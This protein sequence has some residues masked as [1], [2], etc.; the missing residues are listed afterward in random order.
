VVAVASV[1]E[2]L[3]PWAVVG[4]GVVSGAGVLVLIHA[5]RTWLSLV[6]AVRAAH[7][8]D[9]P[10]PSPVPWVD[11]RLWRAANG[12]DPDL[13]A[14]MILRAEVEPGLVVYPHDV[15]PAIREPLLRPVGDAEQAL[16][17]P[18]PVP[19]EAPVPEPGD[20]AALRTA[21]E[22]ATVGR[23]LVLAPRWP[24]C[25][26]RLSTL[27]ART[28]DPHDGSLYL[29]GGRNADGNPEGP[30][31]QHTYQCRACGRRYRTEPHW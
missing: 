25:C 29:P 28:A 24:V 10:D 20:L 26:G 16:A 13:D 21:L 14:S 23:F 31:G 5:R 6:D 19:D 8:H 4:G 1:A 17:S 2:V 9:V 27:T 11:D 7:A 22:E 30:I 15:G 18:A 12:F 3:P